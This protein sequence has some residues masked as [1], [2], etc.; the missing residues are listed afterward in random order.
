MNYFTTVDRNRVATYIRWSTDEQS[1]GTTLEVQREACQLFIQ[2]QGWTFREDLIFVDDGHSGGSMDRPGLTRLRRAVAEGQVNC[3][4]VYKLDRLSRSVLDTVSLVLKEWDGICS[5][6]STREPVDTTNPTGSILFYMLASY[7]EWE[8]STI[9]ERTM[10]GKIKRAQQGRNPGFTPPYGYSTGTD[11]GQFVIFDQEA[12]VIRRIFREY[13]SG[14]GI[15]T[16]A[17]GLNTD[18]IKPR[19]ADYWRPETI[20]KMVKN[21]VYMGVLRYG[22]STLT[23][24]AQ[25]K[26]LGK[27][28]LFLDEP[29]YANVSGVVPALITEDEFE[30][31]QRVRA[32]RNTTEG[33]RA[34]AADFLL[35]GIARCR[36][37][38]T[39]RGDGREKKGKRYYRCSAARISTPNRCD[40]GLI[41]ARKLEETVLAQVRDALAPGNRAMLLAT[42]EEDNARR[43]Q[44]VEGEI[45]QIKSSL[46]QVDKNRARF[47]A[48]YK[49][50]DLPAKLYAAHCDDLDREEEALRAS[51]GTLEAECSRLKDGHKDMAELERMARQIESWDE[52]DPEEKKQVLRYAIARCVV[53][54][55]GMG[56]GNHSR[57]PSPV[58]VELEIRQLGA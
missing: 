47:T 36:C 23:T 43:R 40:C 15:H 34:R 55:Q 19:R 22:L 37:G 20:Y 46:A 53:Y 7:A 51:L 57:N 11:A 26:Q 14:K 6:R 38:A 25:R 1:D 9:K 10:S 39:L 18:G 49:A 33:C 45:L 56:P 4:V 58:E 21:P 2:S 27:F 44:T 31:A 13:T 5:V 3:V 48:D 28:R 17:A 50:G 29:R 12:A 16:I 32:S 30:R 42:W 41:A 52:L 24:P 35:S 8:R 54:R